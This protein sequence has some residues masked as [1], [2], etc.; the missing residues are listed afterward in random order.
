MIFVILTLLGMVS[1]GVIDVDVGCVFVLVLLVVVVFVSVSVSVY[2][3]RPG[4]CVSMLRA[5][6]RLP[7]NLIPVFVRHLML[8]VGVCLLMGLLLMMW[9]LS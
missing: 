6:V 4:Q 9:R 2:V 1:H 7:T 3:G 8:F 5:A